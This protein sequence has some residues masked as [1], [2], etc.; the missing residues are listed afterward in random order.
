MQIAGSLRTREQRSPLRRASQRVPPPDSAASA[1]PIP[2]AIVGAV[3]IGLMV[4]LSLLAP[5]IARYGPDVL[6]ST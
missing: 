2:N 5:L 4:V 6:I 1:D 3:L